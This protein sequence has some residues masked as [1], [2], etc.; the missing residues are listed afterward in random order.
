MDKSYTVYRNYG[1]IKTLPRGTADTTSPNS[2]T[3]I[4]HGILQTIIEKLCQN[5]QHIISYAHRAEFEENSLMVD[6]VKVCNEVVLNYPILLSCKNYTSFH[7]KSMDITPN[8]SL[9]LAKLY[10]KLQ[11]SILAEAFWDILHYSI[12]HMTRRWHTTDELKIVISGITFSD[13]Y[14]K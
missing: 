13:Y 4:H 12:Y 5:R 3:T 7:I 8:V 9:S 10:T 14:S 6:H 1:G 2:L 11:P